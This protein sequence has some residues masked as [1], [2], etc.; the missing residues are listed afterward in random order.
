MAFETLALP[1][2]M[3]VES[4]VSKVQSILPAWDDAVIDIAPV[5]HPDQRGH[6]Y[7]AI[8][9]FKFDESYNDRTLVIGG[10]IAEEHG[11]ESLN[12]DGVERLQMSTVNFQKVKRLVD[13]MPHT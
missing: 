10:W 3:R 1:S 8:F 13:T 2:G 4:C 5:I 6:K 9:T 7:M 12:V 11:G